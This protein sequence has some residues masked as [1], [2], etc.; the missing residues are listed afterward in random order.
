L[1][2]LFFLNWCFLIFIFFFSFSLLFL[3]FSFYWVSLQLFFS[4]SPPNIFLIYKYLSNYKF[5]LISPPMI[6]YLS[7]LILII[8]IAIYFVWGHLFFFLNSNFIPILFVSFFFFS[9]VFL[10]IF[11]QWINP[12]KL[13]LLRI[14]VFLL[15]LS[16]EFYEL[17][18]LDIR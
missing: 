5:F 3:W 6:F 16:L 7:N 13:N 4:I 11:F 18:V 10:L 1:H 17:R 8:F 9:Q 2:E 14:K 15:N 12:T